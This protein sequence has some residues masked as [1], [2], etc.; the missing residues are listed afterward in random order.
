MAAENCLQ[1][2]RSRYSAYCCK[3][4]DYIYQTYHPDQQ[5]NNSKTQIAEFANTVHFVGLTIAD[6]QEDQRILISNT[7][8]VSFIAYYINGNKLEALAETSRFVFS[9]RW[10]YYDGVIAGTTANDIGRNDRCPCG[11]GKKF[12]QCTSHLNSGANPY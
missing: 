7:G 12:K 4:I 5:R 8:S 11:S 1:L 9:D 6:K 3:H 2:M 10:Y